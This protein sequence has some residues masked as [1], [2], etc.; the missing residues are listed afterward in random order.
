MILKELVVNKFALVHNLG[1]LIPPDAL[2]I[3]CQRSMVKFSKEPTGQGAELKT[4]FQEQLLQ[5]SVE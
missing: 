4:K 5:R 1:P 3:K 2:L